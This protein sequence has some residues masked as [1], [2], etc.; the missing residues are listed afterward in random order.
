MKSSV[1][2]LALLASLGST[3]EFSWVADVPEYVQLAVSGLALFVFS[4][5]LR[6]RLR[7]RSA[8]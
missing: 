4:G 7:K 8:A 2:G 3:L 1:L 5:A 6:S